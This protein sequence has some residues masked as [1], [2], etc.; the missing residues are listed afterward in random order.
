MDV[1]LYPQPKELTLRQQ[2]SGAVPGRLQAETQ[3]C[4]KLG[5]QTYTL[6]I[7]EGR[8]K[9]QGGSP[10][11]L[12]MA[13]QTLKQLEILY[14]DQLPSLYIKDWP[15]VKKRGFMLD[16]SR[17]KIPTLETLKH[18]VDL[19]AL[20]KFNQLQ[21]YMESPCFKY[22]AYEKEISDCQGLT[23][24]DIRQLD[25]YCRDRFIELIPNQNSFG[26]LFSWLG[27]QEFKSLTIPGGWDT[28]DPANPD[29]LKFLERLY[30]SLL[31][32]FRSSYLN[33]GCDEVPIDDPQKY[34]DFLMKIYTL[35]KARD[36]KMM[37][38]GDI[39]LNHPEYLEQLPKDLIPLAWGYRK[40]LEEDC[41][42]LHELGFRYYACPGT[43]SWN[44]VFGDPARAA[45][46]MQCAV[47]GVLNFQGDGVLLTDWGDKGHSQFPAVSYP[48]IALF[49]GLCWNYQ[50][51]ENWDYSGAV[52][53][54][55]KVLFQVKNGSLASL[56]L[57]A[58]RMFP[59]R[60]T[61]NDSEPFLWLSMAFYEKEAFAYWDQAKAAATQRRLHEMAEQVR[62][63]ELDCYDGEILK[64]EFC[65]GVAL[66]DL[67][68]DV[69]QMR[70]DR[71]AAGENGTYQY[72]EPLRALQEKSALLQKEHTRI[73]EKRN[74]SQ[75]SDIF[76]N[77]CMGRL[78]EEIQR[79]CQAQAEK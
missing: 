1:N 57:E 11:A 15:D 73:W 78:F 39:I 24:E 65:Q 45:F 30:D 29:S 60:S 20:L 56:L 58:G 50:V 4:G 22:P 59:K 8:I 44:T 66:T 9:L 70:L 74:F 10:A 46:N 23:P 75:G 79:N 72:K 64:E 53:F 18:L 14:P 42:K 16:I 68:F 67:F 33:V 5:P 27:R 3:L 71:Y 28:L 63:L 49:S 36:H 6:Q 62:A 52:A 17:G 25:T 21:L 19:L 37:F 12:F 32:C 54:L 41:R 34:F 69:F 48:A 31:P 76:W 55:D 51:Y 26:H 43:S 13:G 61:S 35:V 47:K 7:Q 40:S 2:S 77:W 38:W